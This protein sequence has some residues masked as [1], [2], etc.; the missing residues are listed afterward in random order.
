[1]TAAI[2]SMPFLG[3]NAIETIDSLGV[4]LMPAI[5]LGVYLMFASGIRLLSR[6]DDT[7]VGVARAF[8]FSLVPIALAYNMAHFISLLLIQG[9]LIIPLASDPFGFGWDL[10]GTADYRVNI[11]V[12][13]AKVAW[14]IAVGAIVLGHIISVY[15]AHVVALRR[16]DDHA[17]AIRGQYPMLLLMVLY[18]ATRLW[19]LAQ[20]IVAS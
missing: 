8:V 4:V 14:F 9:Q 20:P 6:D 16:V 1:Q 11:G 3:R 7:G 5:F 2:T 13:N 19:I 10:L 15:V 17:L 12:I 18:T